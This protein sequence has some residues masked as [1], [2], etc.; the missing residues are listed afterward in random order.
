MCPSRSEFEDVKMIVQTAAWRESGAEE[1][2]ANCQ[3]F[4]RDSQKP[5][6]HI[7]Y[8]TLS[9][10]PSIHI[11]INNIM[12][13]YYHSTNTFY[14]FSS[15]CQR[16]IARWSDVMQCLFT[17]KQKRRHCVDLSLHEGEIDVSL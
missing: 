4:R 7:Q 5:N 14:D 8:L 1:Q 3:S 11:I 9:S 2:T 10:Q 13:E 16:Q 12:N 6:M 15:W 17:D